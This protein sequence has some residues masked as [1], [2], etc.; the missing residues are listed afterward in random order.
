MFLMLPSREEE[1]ITE[2]MKCTDAT[3]K[4]KTMRSILS[5]LLGAYLFTQ[6]W[7]PSVDGES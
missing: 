6:R 4:L 1:Q 2:L 7:S 3:Q 5:F